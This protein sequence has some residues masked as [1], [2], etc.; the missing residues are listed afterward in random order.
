MAESMPGPSSEW[1]DWILPV[2][3]KRA[4]QT[5]VTDGRSVCDIVMLLCPAIL[6]IVKAST[7]SRPRRVNMVCRNECTTKSSGN[8][9]SSRTLACWWSSD[10]TR[11]G[12]PVFPGNTCSVKDVLKRASN[13]VRTRAVTRLLP[14]APQ[15]ETWVF[16]GF[17]TAKLIEPTT[18]AV[19]LCIGESHVVVTFMAT[20]HSSA[21]VSGSRNGSPTHPRAM[22]FLIRCHP[23]GVIAFGPSVGGGERTPNSAKAA[24]IRAVP[25]PARSYSLSTNIWFTSTG[26]VWPCS[27]SVDGTNVTSPIRLPQC[28][29]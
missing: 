25:I 1:A 26:V 14:P 4:L 16:A 22:A 23:S 2:S 10:V 13:M 11:M 17:V 28:E 15:A 24:S 7:P 29:A 20:L 6:M 3:R 27:I 5:P 8:F 12:L 18:S 9:K 19:S 21:S